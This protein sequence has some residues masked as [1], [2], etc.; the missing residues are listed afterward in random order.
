[1]GAQ[2]WEGHNRSGKTSALDWGKN[3]L[4][5]LEPNAVIFTRGDNDTFPLWYVQEVEEYRTDVRVAN[6][7]LSSGYW[8]VH[9]M[10]RKTY[11]SENCLSH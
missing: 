9:Q 11:D 8:Y 4:T 5:N 2:G 1:M 3:Y 6:F 7:M 10:A